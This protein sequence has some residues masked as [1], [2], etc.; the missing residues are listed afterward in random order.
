M[1]KFGYN[2]GL[3]DALHRRECTLKN[4]KPA[5]IESRKTQLN[6]NAVNT[7]R[8]ALLAEAR[9]IRDMLGMSFRQPVLALNA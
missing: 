5:M 8:K 3:G 4:S 1:G 6:L 2:T 9:A 7:S